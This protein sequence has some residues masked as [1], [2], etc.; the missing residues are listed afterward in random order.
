M[1]D[2]RAHE[3]SEA[4]ERKLLVRGQARIEWAAERQAITFPRKRPAGRNV[5]GQL[6]IRPRS[7]SRNYSARERPRFQRDFQTLAARLP[8][9]HEVGKARGRI[10]YSELNVGPIDVEQRCIEG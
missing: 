2:A 6:G 8:T 7:V 5:L 9:I 10:A 4:R 3:T 1:R